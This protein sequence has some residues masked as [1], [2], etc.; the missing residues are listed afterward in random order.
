M[1]RARLSWL[2]FAAFG[3]FGVSA[4]AQQAKEPALSLKIQAR[5]AVYFV[6]DGKDVPPNQ[7][8]C[9]VAIECELLNTGTETLEL[10]IAPEPELILT[11]P[12]PASVRKSG[13]MF[14]VE[15][16]QPMSLAPGKP[17]RVTFRTLA[18]R[19]GTS[20]FQLQW[21][22]PGDYQLQAIYHIS[23]NAK[24]KQQ[25]KPSLEVKSETLKLTVRAGSVAGYW[26]D[27]LTDKDLELC[28][29]A[30]LNLRDM[31]P[32]AQPAAPALARVMGDV[33][34]EFRISVAKTLEAIG[35]AC[36]AD[37]L[38][39]LSKAL[40]DENKDVQRAAITALSVIAPTEK[41]IEPAFLAFLG[42]MDSR[43]RLAAADGLARNNQPEPEIAVALLRALKTETE[44]GVRRSLIRGLRN[45]PSL[46]VLAEL[47]PFIIG[48]EK[49][50][51]VHALYTLGQMAAF[52]ERDRTKNEKLGHPIEK[53]V[54]A[55]V[56][57]MKD[58][59]TRPNA[60]YALGYFGPD[61]ESSVPALLELL[62]EPSNQ[63]KDSL[64]H[65]RVAIV[66]ALRGIGPGAKAATRA[67]AWRVVTDSDWSVRMYAAEALGSIGPAA[68]VAGPALNQALKDATE[69]VRNEAAPALAKIGAVNALLDGLSDE[70]PRTRATV[71][72]ALG[73]MKAASKQVVPALV[74]TLHE[75]KDSANRRQAAQAL[76]ALGTAARDAV[77]ELGKALKDTDEGVRLAAANALRGL[78]K[79]ASAAMDALVE[80]MANDK[81][82]RNRETAGWALVSI[83]LKGQ[84]KYVTRLIDL[85]NGEP[86]VALPAVYLLG[87]IGPDARN[88]AAP[89]RRLQKGQTGQLVDAIRIALMQIES[90]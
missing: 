89:L 51:R 60:I 81:S 77:P 33:D 22:E 67:L 10:R 5:R 8:S 68:N 66:Q 86:S 28:R 18:Y 4:E 27:A 19:S 74:K 54:A 63:G 32:R 47:T 72:Q 2:A 9:P 3:A 55:L 16:E 61:A 65:S 88:A 15:Q 75:D 38:P 85:L 44:E 78:G 56:Q 30:L 82:V 42:D 57:A 62:A 52:L 21:L 80:C 48:G 87:Q 58:P 35:P 31:G 17:Y 14:F 83:H 12:R 64:H 6:G 23:F 11:G 84:E 43:T 90:R 34:P 73:T 25:A 29:I 1:T 79:D 37:A 13:H 50:T 26:A 69:Q 76:W 70:N 53:A 39:V 49:Q 24:A 41:A 20:Q 45:H 7:Y 46:E 59:D 71:I 40:R 36:K